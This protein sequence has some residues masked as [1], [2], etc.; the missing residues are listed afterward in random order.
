MHGML[1]LIQLVG[2]SFQ[3]W[4]QLLLLSLSTKPPHYKPGE[5]RVWGSLSSTANV[6][7]P[8]LVLRG[9]SPSPRWDTRPRSPGSSEGAA[10]TAGRL[11]PEGGRSSPPP[12]RW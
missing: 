11:R 8:R 3:I 12:T 10:R 1:L 6:R 9:S 5:P 4:V 2:S 7:E